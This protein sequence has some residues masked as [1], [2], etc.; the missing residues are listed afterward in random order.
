MKKIGNN[1][2]NVITITFGL[3]IVL[4]ISAIKRIEERYDD[5]YFWE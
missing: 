2:F 3:A 1:M 4:F 5:T